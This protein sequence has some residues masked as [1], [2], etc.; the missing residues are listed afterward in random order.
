MSELLSERALDQLFRNARTFNAWL[1]KDV[2]DEQLQQIYEL[3]KFGPTSANSSPM[4]VVFVKSKDAKAR[5]EPFLSEGNRAKTMEAP[6]TAIIATDH[7]FHEQL[8]KLFPH[9]DA[10]SWF[11]GNQPLIDT[12]AFRNATLQ[13]AYVLMAARALGLDCGPMSGFDNAA[14]DAAFFAGTAIKSNFL[15]SI[16]YG[17]ASRNLFPRSPRLAFDEACKIA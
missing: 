4:R 12:T 1:P 11:V 5:L 7:E 10:R 16:G 3:A 6:V 15:I 8:P 13:G 9:A 17:D 14:V 2:S